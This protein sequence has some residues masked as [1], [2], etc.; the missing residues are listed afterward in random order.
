MFLA[1]LTHPH[2]REPQKRT[3]QGSQEKQH[4]LIDHVGL[5]V[6]LMTGSA[7]ASMDSLICHLYYFLVLLNYA[8]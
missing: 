6:G 7:L 2:T 1:G 3:N 5:L 4:N 8:L